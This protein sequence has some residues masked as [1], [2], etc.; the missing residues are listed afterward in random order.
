[1]TENPKK[2]STTFRRLLVYLIIPVLLSLFF[3]GGYFSGNLRL[4]ELITPV[5]NREYGLLENFQNLLLL[6]VILLSGYGIIRKR[7]PL[8]KI[9][10]GCILAGALFLFLEEI[11][12]GRLHY[13]YISGNPIHDRENAQDWNLHNLSDLNHFMKLGLDIGMIVF[14]IIFPMVTW[15]STSRMIRYLRPDPWF[16]LTMVLM[17]V[18]SR[19]SKALARAGL[20]MDGALRSNTAEFREVIVYYVFLVYIL[21]FI[22]RRNYLTPEMSDQP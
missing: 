7:L 1:M 18:V 15:K 12:Y 14:F 19:Y 4:Q 17:L 3:I 13:Y 8:E 11:D 9:F 6:A 22:F 21:T 10:L 5:M 2:E 16:M 20:G